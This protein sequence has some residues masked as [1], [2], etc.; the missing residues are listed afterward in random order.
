M[1]RPRRIAAHD[2][3]C[4]LEVIEVI[5]IRQTLTTRNTLQLGSVDTVKAKQR[6]NI[7]V[8]KMVMKQERPL[9]EVVER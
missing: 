3:D 5:P 8:V 2:R 1:N 6:A 9:A 7:R 4:I